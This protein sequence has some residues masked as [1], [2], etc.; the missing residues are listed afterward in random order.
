MLSKQRPKKLISYRY[1]KK[2]NSYQENYQMVDGM[3]KTTAERQNVLKALHIH[4]R[5]I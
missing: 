2:K 4:V 1:K 5:I 3:S